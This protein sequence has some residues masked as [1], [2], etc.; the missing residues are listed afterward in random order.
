MNCDTFS[1]PLKLKKISTKNTTTNEIQSSYKI[2]IN[3]DRFNTNFE[4]TSTNEQWLINLSNTEISEKAKI[5]LQLGQQFNLPNNVVSKERSIREFKHVE[6]NLFRADDEVCKMV[7]NETI[8]I[9]ES[10][11][12][13]IIYEGVKEVKRFISENP[14]ILITREDKGNTIV[15]INRESY[16]EKIYEI[17]N[18]Q[19]TYNLIN[20]DPT[21]KITSEISNLLKNWKNKGYIDLN[22]YKKL[23]VS[24]GEFPSS[25]GLPKIHK[26]GHPLR[27]I[28]SCINS[29]FYPL[30]IFL[31]EIIDNNNKKNFS[32]VKNSFY[33]VNKLNEN[34]ISSFYFRYVDDI[35]LVV[36]KEKVEGILELFNSYHERLKFTVDFG[37]ENGI[38]FLDVKLMSIIFHI[39]K[40]PTNS[41]RYLNYF[42][43]H[44]LVHKRGVII[45]QLDRILLLSHP[46]F[47]FIRLELGSCENLIN[48]DQ[49][50]NSLSLMT[51]HAFII[52]FFIVIPFIITL[53]LPLTFN[54]F[55]RRPSIEY[56]KILSLD[57]IPLLV[58]S[59]LVAAVLL[60]LF[61]PDLAGVTINRS[62]TDRNLNTSFFDLSGGGDPILY[63]HLSH[64]QVYI[65][66]LPGFRLIESLL[67]GIKINYNSIGYIFLFS[68][69][70]FTGIILSNSS[71]D[72]ILYGIY[73]VV[74]HFHYIKQIPSLNHTFSKIPSIK[75]KLS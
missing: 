65:L 14:D 33:L 32:Y 30:A 55:H 70:G 5:V 24:D 47:H 49:I 45:G 11:E 7:R 34:I 42:S 26:E 6:H 39:Y 50:Y 59:I 73:Y 22:L 23:Y 71:I 63:Q 16:R 53:Y 36:H 1:A 64:P 8:Q 68:I 21:N 74:V 4:I 52:I 72:I 31:K 29:A 57:K 9:L 18:D 20:K 25:Y 10:A 58:R 66:I 28:V 75:K 46:K 3:P 40:K 62:L 51:N 48:N 43:N 41:G 44:P 13:K 15:I 35:V 37:D 56:Q 17:L 54:I 60:L 67:Y 69:G 2:N 19:I 61:L 12:N 27:L 38:N